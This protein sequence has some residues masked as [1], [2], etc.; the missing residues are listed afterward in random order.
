MVPELRKG[1]DHSS[2]V[3]VPS[4]YCI[5]QYGPTANKYMF[6]NVTVTCQLGNKEAF[7]SF[8]PSHWFTALVNQWQCNGTVIRCVA[9][10]RWA[11]NE[12]PLNT[13]N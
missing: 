11:Y 5:I 6:M 10:D 8:T 3:E 9:D 13:Q 4:N 12:W 2:H 1:H 7:L